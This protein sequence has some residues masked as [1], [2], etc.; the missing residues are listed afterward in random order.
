MMMISSVIGALLNRGRGT[1]FWEHCPSTT[2]TRVMFS[3]GMGVLA[4]FM[5]L[6]DLRL[7]VEVLLW[8][9][10]SMYFWSVWGWDRFWSSAIGDD[11]QHNRLWGLKMLTLR[12]SLGIPCLVGLSWL[13]GHWTAFI[14]T[15][16]LFGLPYFISGYVTPRRFVVAVP[17][18]MIGATWGICYSNILL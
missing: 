9:T 2:L 16:L 7:F 18:M 8:V 12:H 14:L 17:E 6:P 4:A 11:S 15:P 10:V 5:V 13:T 3:Y 1:R